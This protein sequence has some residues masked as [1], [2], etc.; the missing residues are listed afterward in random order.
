[1]DIGQKKILLKAPDPH[2]PLL[3]SGNHCRLLMCLSNVS[4]CLAVPACSLLICRVLLTRSWRILPVCTPVRSVWGFPPPSHWMGLCKI[5]LRF[6]LPTQ[7]REKKILCYSSWMHF[8]DYYRDW[9]PFREFIGHFCFFGFPREACWSLSVWLWMCLYFLDFQYVLL[10]VLS[11]YAVR[12]VHSWPLNC[13]KS[14]HSSVKK[15]PLTPDPF[16][17]LVKSLNWSYG[18]PASLAPLLPP[19]FRVSFQNRFGFT[20]Y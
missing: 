5:C 9:S 15:F 17:F 11:N 3:N 19:C 8:F 20:G 16:M 1:M 12:Y 13:P 6:V 14:Y 18:F 10:C 7:R 4:L 2:I